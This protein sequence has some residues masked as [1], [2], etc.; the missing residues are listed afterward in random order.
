MWKQ[1]SKFGPH[2]DDK[3]SY[4]VR[5]FLQNNVTSTDNRNQ[6]LIFGGKLVFSHFTFVMVWTITCYS[7]TVYRNS[8]VYEVAKASFYTI[9][10]SSNCVLWGIDCNNDKVQ[11][12]MAISDN[13]LYHKILQSLMLVWNLAVGSA[14]TMISNLQIYS[15]WQVLILLLVLGGLPY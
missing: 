6:R 2:I 7:T 4:I 8:T 9:P 1:C 5:C 3:I 15:A 13:T 14:V 10:D 11:T 12:D